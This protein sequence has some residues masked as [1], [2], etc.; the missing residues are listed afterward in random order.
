MPLVKLIA[1]TQPCTLTGPYKHHLH[2]IDTPE[3]LIVHIARVSNP[4][5][6]FNPDAAKLIRYLKAHAHWSPFEM[7][8]ITV[9]IKC[10]RAIAQ[11]L[12]RHRSFVFQEF[13]QRYAEASTVEPVLLRKQAEKNRQSSTELINSPNL[14]KLVD[15]TVAA[16]MHAYH[17]LIENGVARECARAVLPLNTSTT[18]YMKGSLRSWIHYLELRTQ[19][20]TQ[21][22]HREIACAIQEI[23]R[24]LFPNVFEQLEAI[25]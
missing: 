17:T 22:E 3:K 1:Y 5:N 19:P 20:N 6:Q 2:Q 12:L 21:L 16:S 24:P 11:Q 8:D 14:A 23:L 4:G 18:I 25:I 15:D 9:E 13:S 7:V 10:A